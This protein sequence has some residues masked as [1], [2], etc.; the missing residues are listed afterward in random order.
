MSKTIAS[1]PT[2][3]RSFVHRLW[4][5]FLREIA[6]PVGM[7][8]LVIFFVIQAFKIPSSSMENTLLIGD[9][10]LG[11]KFVYGSPL[12]FTEAKLPGLQDPEPGDVV[13]FRY[14]GD[15]E[16]PDYQPERYTHLAN[17]LM[18]GNFFWDKEAKEGEHS[19]VHYPMGPKD[20]IKRCVAKSGQVVEVK[21]GILYV[22]GQ[23]HNVP[24]FGLY[25]KPYRENSP[26]DFWGPAKIPGP[27]DTLSLVGVPIT[28]LW[29]NRSLMIQE[30]PGHRVELKLDLLR[31][32][33]LL[34][35]FVFNDFRVKLNPN[36]SYHVPMRYF[37]ENVRTGFIPQ[38]PGQVD[39]E[40]LP[41]GLVRS[42]GYV[43]MEPSQLE[44]L[45]RNVSRLNQEG[46][47]LRLQWTVLFDGSPI[48]KYPVQQKAYFMMGDNR[49]NS[50]DSRYWGYVSHRNIKA[51]AFIIYFSIDNEDEGFT[52]SN[53]ISWFTLPAKIRWSRFGKLIQDI[54][55]PWE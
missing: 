4:R 36:E 41:Q 21:N 34:N 47:S 38:M 35:D 14:P 55:R 7:A 24:G 30:N 52:F 27:G 49:D 54:G 20:F 29:F 3:Q 22:D 44:E 40:I 16:I 31:G 23:S 6:M 8:L 18:F 26:R 48:Q 11:L 10:L 5:G 17:L 45:E 15:P 2:T 1:S 13:I 42:V 25:A 37:I 28:K 19:I 33:S 39:G 43:M 50:A 51:K 32:S 46:D 53:P 12:P 9:F